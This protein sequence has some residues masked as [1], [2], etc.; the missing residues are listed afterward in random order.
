MNER[1]TSKDQ[2]VQWSGSAAKGWVGL[3][4]LLD[5]LLQPFETLLVEELS[6]VKPTRVLDIGCG[7][8]ATTAAVARHF[9]A[10]C[11][12]VDISPA[13]IDA[14]R[15]RAR[16]EGLDVELITADA[17]SHP[18][19]PGTFD[20]LISRFG[21]MFF[22]DP[23]AAFSNLRRSAR[24]GSFL[25]FVVWRGPVEN[26]FMTTA[27]RAARPLLPD[28]PERRASEPGQFGLADPEHVRRILAAS[29]WTETVLR[30]VDLE[31]AMPVEAFPSYVTQL[32]PVGRALEEADDALRAAVFAM[33]RPAFDPYVRGAEVRF[34]AACWM[35]AARA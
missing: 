4:S 13:M 16:Q 23:I 17:Q 12:G 31:C 5:D 32:G 6:S 19:A 34:D 25:R 26:P 27:E 22:D 8:G 11:T 9:G 15:A 1:S 18:F 21:V 14:A 28:L 3:Q 7:T 35:I 10:R 2:A 24:E 29:G 33:V 30:A 20:A